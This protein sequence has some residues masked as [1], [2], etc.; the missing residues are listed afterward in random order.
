MRILMTVAGTIILLLAPALPAQEIFSDGFEN[1][2]TCLWSDVTDGDDTQLSARYL[3]ETDDC[4]GN[5][6]SWQ[7]EVHDPDDVDF[8]IHHMTEA[9]LGCAVNTTVTIVAADPLDYCVYFSCDSGNTV[10]TCPANTIDAIADSGAIGCCS[11]S[12][13]QNTIQIQQ[14]CAGAVDLHGMVWT[15]VSTSD[16]AGGACIPYGLVV[17]N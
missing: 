3:G 17:H 14:D 10:V 4:D 5:Q 15:E 2:S 6:F 13:V 11:V 1:G 12:D 8:T 7:G 16:G 9:P